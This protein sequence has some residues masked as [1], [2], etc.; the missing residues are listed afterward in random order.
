MKDGE[1]ESGRAMG[2]ALA[3]RQATEAIENAW[4]EHGNSKIKDTNRCSICA[5][6]AKSLLAIDE[7]N[8]NDEEVLA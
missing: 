2:Y 5:T 6:F 3:L 8:Y 7:L 1:Y 4:D